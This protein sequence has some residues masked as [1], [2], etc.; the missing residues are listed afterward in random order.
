[1]NLIQTGC[2]LM[3]KIHQLVLLDLED[4][5]NLYH[6]EIEKKCIHVSECVHV[7][8]YVCLCDCKCVSVILGGRLLL[9]FIQ[10]S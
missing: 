6:Y 4:Y 10:H 8:I 5:K 2:F 1:M 9:E 7:C 3:E